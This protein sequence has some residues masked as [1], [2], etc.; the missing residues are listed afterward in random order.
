MRNVLFFN[1]R[2]N[3]MSLFFVIFGLISYGDI[4]KSFH[5]YNIRLISFL[6]L[7]WFCY[8]YYNECQL[9]KNVKNPL[10][11]NLTAAAFKLKHH[12]C[13]QYPKRCDRTML[14][15]YLGDSRP[16]LMSLFQRWFF[17]DPKNKVYIV[18]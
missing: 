18:R 3:A 10:S 14:I 5:K 13:V 8:F 7:L 4:C 17:C 9:K 2:L 11:A 15:V 16:N 6:L 12:P 1:D